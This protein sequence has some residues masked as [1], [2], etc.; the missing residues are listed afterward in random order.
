MSRRWT[1][2]PSR[3]PRP[4]G[5]LAG[6]AV[7]R[8]T[9]ARLAVEHRHHDRDPRRPD[10]VGRLR[11]CRGSIGGRARHPVAIPVRRRVRAR[12]RRL[13]AGAIVP[14]GGGLRGRASDG[15][16]ARATLGRMVEPVPRR[17]GRLPSS[18]PDTSAWSAPS[19]SRRW[20]TT[21]SS[22]RP[23]PTASQPSAVARSR[24][25]RPGV[26]EAL[27]AALA[28]GTLS[29]L[30]R[31][32]AHPG[33]D[34]PDL[35][36][37]PDRRS[38][39]GRYERRRAR[40]A[41][42]RRAGDRAD[43][44]RPQHPAGR[45]LRA[46][47]CARAGSA[48]RPGSSRSPSSSA[49]A[50]R[51][52]TS[53]GPTGSSSGAVRTRIPPRATSSWRCSAAFD[54]PLLVVTLEESELIKNG[55]NAYLA[56]KISFANEIAGLAERAG[57][58]RRPRAPGDR[59]R[60][61]D[62]RLVLDPSFGFGGS[63]LPEGARDDRRSPATSAASRC[64]SRPPRPRPTRRTSASS[65][66]GSPASSVAWRARIALLGLAFKAGTDDI[67]SSPAVALARLAARPTA[68]VVHA[69]RPGGGGRAAARAVP[70]LVVHD[71]ALDALEGADAAS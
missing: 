33:V 34:R 12:S 59:P 67:R 66:S 25:P 38:W 56:L 28:A 52:P 11:R 55:A 53:A 10:G 27:T 41:G 71:T 63:C 18:A 61:A 54:A 37:D 8:P 31:A 69:V 13:A 68:R 50:P 19:G 49:R 15:A 21:S 42:A 51:W 16:S 6:D 39:P 30:E 29:I 24:S 57:R 14:V 70:G 32:S 20:A 44:R 47:A 65:P 5:S 35:R 9:Q 64:T 43:R 23:I 26:Q 40:A 22:S 45:D 3:R 4:R 60:P 58:R 48:T 1:R 7:E 46:A 36:R 17:G 62:R 2:R